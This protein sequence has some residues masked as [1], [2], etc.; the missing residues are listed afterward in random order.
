MIEPVKNGIAVVISQQQA[1]W[2]LRRRPW[3]ADVP[4]RSRKL[5]SLLDSPREGWAFRIATQGIGTNADLFFEE[6]AEHPDAFALQLR[7]LELADDFPIIDRKLRPFL[8]DSVMWRLFMAILSDAAKR[9]ATSRSTVAP[10]AMR[11]AVGTPR[12]TEPAAPRAETAPVTTAPCAT[13]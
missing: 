6:A 12:V 4:K 8:M 10:L 7:A 2:R 11:P 5:M 9:N 13:A 1:L 3:G